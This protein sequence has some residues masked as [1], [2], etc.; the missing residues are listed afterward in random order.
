MTDNRTTTTRI[1]M[2]GPPGSGKGT[3]AALLSEVL[4]VPAISTGE[5]LRQA[6]ETGS[7]LG[8]RV[9]EIVGS[10]ALVDDPTMADVVRARLAQDDAKDGFLLDGYPRTIEQVRALDRI[11]EELGV[12]LE[13]VI[14]V[15][16]P[17][18][19]LIR[20]ALARRR[21]DD[22]EEVIQHRLTVY[23]EKTQPLVEHYREKGQL[24]TVDGDKSIAQVATAVQHLVSR[25]SN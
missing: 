15:D 22:T 10:G 3:Q 23:R 11:L 25:G 13:M 6:I 5:M 18:R 12:A 19:E 8:L 21:E 2:L 4:G 16:A 14:F 1:V 20:R 17:E 7:E 24:E 9:A